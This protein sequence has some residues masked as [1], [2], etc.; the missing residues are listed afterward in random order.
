MREIIEKAEVAKA[1][2]GASARPSHNA[3]LDVNLMDLTIPSLD[4]MSLVRL[5]RDGMSASLVSEMALRVGLGQDKLLEMLR[6]SRSTIKGRIS[7]KETLSPMEADRIYRLMQLLARASEALGSEG[8]A[9]QWLRQELRALGGVA[10]IELL[11]TEPG[12][13]LVMDTLGRIE[14]GVIG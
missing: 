1:Q 14:A 8:D 2:S 7:K 12:Y 9:T 10:P 5:M 6:L 13:E 3:A 4:N 11:D